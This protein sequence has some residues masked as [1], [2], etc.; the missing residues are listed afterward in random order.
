MRYPTGLQPGL[1][2]SRR[3][4]TAKLQEATYATSVQTMG[5]FAAHEHVVL[6]LHFDGVGPRRAA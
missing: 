1:F 3:S 5:V 6:L 2:R 4:S